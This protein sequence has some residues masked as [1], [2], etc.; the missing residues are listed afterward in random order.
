MRKYVNLFLGF[1][2]SAFAATYF[3]YSTPNNILDSF[4][5]HQLVIIT[6]CVILVPVYFL[7]ALKYF[8][9]LQPYKVDFYR[10]AGAQF[11][12]IGLNNLL[13]FRIGDVLRTGYVYK[14]LTVPMSAAIISLLVERGIDFGIIL[15]LLIGFCFIFF[16]IEIFQFLSDFCTLIVILFLGF[17]GTGLMAW[18]LTKNRKFNLNI[19]KKI[20]SFWPLNILSTFVVIFVA[21]AQWFL[22]IIILGIVLSKLVLGDSL[23]VGVLATFMSNLST[24]V[25]SAPGYFGTFE[26]AGISAFQIVGFTDLKNAAGFVLILHASIWLFSTVLGILAIAC[27]PNTL[28]FVRQKND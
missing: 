10:L 24:L 22:E 11:A 1:T 6:G 18:Y 9:I 17:L 7:R 14:V 12:G 2:I 8:L 21:I 16:P 28:T 15:M 13:P 5:K 19:T 23:S 25:P 4:F 20:R 27:L 26:A 3:I